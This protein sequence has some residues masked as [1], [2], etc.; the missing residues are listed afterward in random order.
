[1]IACKGK[2]FIPTNERPFAV[3]ALEF[4]MGI[5]TEEVIYSNAWQTA[6]SHTTPN[7]L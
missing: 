3:T 5:Q 4:G 2:Q 7:V 6:L 1:M